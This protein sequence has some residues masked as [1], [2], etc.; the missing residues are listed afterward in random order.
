MKDRYMVGETAAYITIIIN[1]ILAIFKVVSAIIAD[2]TAMLADAA[3]TASD[4]LTTVAVIISFKIAKK[5][6]DCE[7]PYGHEKAE[8]IGAKI[9]AL[10]LLFTGFSIGWKSISTIGKSQIIIPGKLA[11]YAALSSILIKEAMFWYTFI[12]AKKINS[13]ALKADAWHHR[14]DAISSVATLIGIAAARMGFP[15]GDAI[16]A[17][18]VS[19]MICKVALDILKKSI[20]ELMDS[21][22]PPETINSLRQYIESVPGVKGIDSLKTRIH[23]NKIYADVEIKVDKSV[24]VSEGHDIAKEVENTV[25]ANMK[26]IKGIMVHIHPY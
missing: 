11:L 3:H 24:S 4:I 8:S 1:I 20:R 6:E 16:S 21:S 25:I 12:I 7:H 15:L 26:N 13:T 14:S 10:L 2:S 17:I 9:V 18:I 5:P 23:G 22:A 19:I